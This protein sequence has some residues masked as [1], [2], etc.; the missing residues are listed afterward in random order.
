MSVRVNEIIDNPYNQGMIQGFLHSNTFCKA[1]LLKKSD[2]LHSLETYSDATSVAIV[3]PGC[4]KNLME[5][6][7]PNTIFLIFL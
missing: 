5:T 7:L 6:T 3:F 1:E 2:P 4:F